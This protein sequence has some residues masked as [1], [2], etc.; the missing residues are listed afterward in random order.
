VSAEEDATKR[1][2]R[3]VKKRG[4]GEKDAGA[5]WADA[6]VPL[7]A[8]CLAL[9]RIGFVG[10]KII[11]AFGWDSR[12]LQVGVGVG[13]SDVSGECDTREI[14]RVPARRSRWKA[15]ARSTRV[16]TYLLDADTLFANDTPRSVSA[17]DPSRAPIASGVAPTP[18]AYASA[19]SRRAVPFSADRRSFVDGFEQVDAAKRQRLSTVLTGLRDAGS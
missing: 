14:G 17:A 4:G 1:K 15:R 16:S 18:S 6:H 3:V 19:R 9:T 12:Y 2:S 8:I 13:V 5:R 11:S 7:L 10:E